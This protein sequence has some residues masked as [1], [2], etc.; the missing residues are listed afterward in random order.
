MPQPVSVHDHLLELAGV[1]L[2]RA[3]LAAELEREVHLGLGEPPVVDVLV[4]AEQPDGPPLGVLLDAE[5][6][7]E[8]C[9]PVDRHRLSPRASLGAAGLGTPGARAASQAA[10]TP[11]CC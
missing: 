4:D 6:L 10:G 1:G 9:A 8:L 11:L 7:F 2:D 5:P 3:R